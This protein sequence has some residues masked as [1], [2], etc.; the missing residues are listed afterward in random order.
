MPPAI[1]GGA[2]AGVGAIGG[3]VIGAGAASSAAKSAAKSAAANNALQREQ[4]QANTQNI[5]PFMDR[6]NQA[7]EKINALLGLNGPGVDWSQYV[8][9]QPDLLKDWQSYA[10]G[11]GLYQDQNDYGQQHFLKY[12]GAEKRDLSGYQTDPQAQGQTATDQL[13][14]MPGYQFRFDEGMN[15]LNTGYAAGGKLQSGSAAKAAIRYGQDY[16]SNE[17]GKQMGYLG[18]QQGVGLTGANALAGVGTNYANS[19]SQ[20][21]NNAAATSA[22]A[23]LAGATMFGNALGGAANGIG[24]AL[25]SSYGKP[26]PQ[27]PYDFT[28]FNN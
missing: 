3:A 14:A 18:N 12:G 13:R 5:Q 15:A 26:R 17:F 28:G 9:E 7:G 11:S 21:N 8:N 4:Y 2:I 6:G 24:Q 19:V 20:N 23:G 22:N 1:I 10:S 16:G 27:M 25:G